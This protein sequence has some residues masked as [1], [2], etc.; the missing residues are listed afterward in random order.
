MELTQIKCPNPKCR[1]VVLL[2]INE[3]GGVFGKGAARVPK[4]GKVEIPCPECGEVI[5]VGFEHVANK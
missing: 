5:T 1:G 2:G 3:F 4:A